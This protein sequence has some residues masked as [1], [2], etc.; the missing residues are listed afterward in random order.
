[1]RYQ[2]GQVAVQVIMWAVGLLTTGSLFWNNINATANAK[3][4]DKISS[5]S[6]DLASVNTSLQYISKSLD[7]L[8]IAQKES[9][10][11]QGISW[12]DIQKL[13]EKNQVIEQK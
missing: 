12:A 4:D 2:R 11:Q 1:M 8:K 13:V 6:S 10:R 7:E 3:Q 5:I 9:L